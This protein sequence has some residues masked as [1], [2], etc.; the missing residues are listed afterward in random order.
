MLVLLRCIDLY[1]I[2]ALGQDASK[3]DEGEFP[4]STKLCSEVF[5]TKLLPTF[6]GGVGRFF[7]LCNC[8]IT[9]IPVSQT[10]EIE[11]H[12]FTTPGRFLSN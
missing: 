8:A 5:I 1:C 9:S 12:A 7:Y 6:Q 10:G 11:F 4:S 3:D 2:G